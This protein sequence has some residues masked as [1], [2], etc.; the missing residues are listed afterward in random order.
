MWSKTQ[1]TEQKKLF[2]PRN[3][4]DSQANTGAFLVGREN[5]KGNVS[6]S[7]KSRPWLKH[8]DGPYAAT[9]SKQ[10]CFSP[11]SSF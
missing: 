2:K 6:K 3:E 1:N 7:V 8:R 5:Q 9:W 11:T 4:L 10:S